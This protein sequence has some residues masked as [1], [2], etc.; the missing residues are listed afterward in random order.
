M[1]VGISAD[2]TVGN[3]PKKG[4]ISKPINPWDERYI[5]DF[6]GFY[7]GD[8]TSP[9][10]FYW[11][12][13]GLSVCLATIIFQG[14]LVGFP[15]QKVE[16]IHLDG[17]KIQWQVA[18]ASATPLQPDGPLLTK[19]L[20]PYHPCRVYLPT[21]AIKANQMYRYNYTI[22]GSYG[23]GG[24]LKEALTSSGDSFRVQVER[25]TPMYYI[26]LL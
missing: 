1:G 16:P 9:I 8:H 12:R 25:T 5:L 21:V 3:F 14:T 10:A 26:V 17:D 22:H 7:V 11:E 4:T 24:D 18:S 19:Q 23:I 15:G 2:F 13:K 20:V 6:D